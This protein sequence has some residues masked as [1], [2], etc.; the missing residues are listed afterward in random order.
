MSAPRNEQPPP[1]DDVAGDTVDEEY[2]DPSE[3]DQV[4][5]LDERARQNDGKVGDGAGDD[6]ED[7]TTTITDDSVMG[8]FSH[9]ESVF[10]ADTFGD[11]AVSGDAADT[12]FVW[13]LSDGET[14]TTLTGHA[15]SVVAVRFTNDG[16]LGMTAAMDGTVRVYNAADWSLRHV[17]SGPASE[18]EWIDVHPH[19]PIIIAGSADSTVWMW[20]AATGQCMNVLSGHSGVVTAGA[21]SSDG[22]IIVSG[23]DHGDLIVFQPKSAEVVHRIRQLHDTAITAIAV[24]PT[25]RLLVTGGADGSVCLVSAETGK[26][27]SKLTAHADS[28]EAI[29]FSPTNPKLV[30]TA[31]VDGLLRVHDTSTGASRVE[32]RHNDPV[33]ALVWHSTTQRIV[34][35][36]MDGRVRM[37]DALTGQLIREYTGH[38]APVLGLTLTGSRILSFGDDHTLLLFDVE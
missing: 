18:L 31:A 17:L 13:R 3:V 19:G 11:I 2:V 28:V 33:T 10:A 36:A 7:D 22:K 37:W 12:C 26:R 38:T 25:S 34:S 20:S 32:C 1:A 27:L 30:A 8:Y 9:T 29:A 24:H 6:G 15:D 5:A 14:L 16:A 35:S 21:F 4:I 23:D